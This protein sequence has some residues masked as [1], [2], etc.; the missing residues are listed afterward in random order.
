MRFFVASLLLAGAVFGRPAEAFAADAGVDFFEK[1]IR[2]VLVQ[3]CYEC[4]SAAAK[5]LRG[6]LLL[7]SRDG[8][9]KGGDSG[10]VIEPTSPE[11]S[12]LLKAIRY[13]DDAVQ[14]PPEGKLPDAVIADFE[15]WVKQG[16]PDPRDEPA[17]APSSESWDETLRK[18][19][20][21][22]SYQPLRNPPVPQPTDS[23][24]S[25][26]PVDRFLLAKLEENHL[27]PAPPA[28]P[29]TL[30]RRLSL[31]L[32]GLPPR[33][34]QVADFAAACS[35]ASPDQPLPL[36]AVAALTESLLASPHFGERWARHWLDV[37]R[38]SETH[39]NEWN[40]EV[41]HA[42]RYRDYL[43]RAFNGDVPYDQFVREHIAGDLLRQPRWNE[44]EMF[45][46]SLI[47]TA[48]YRF[49][50]VNHDD[51]ISLP[52]IGYDLADNQIDTLTKAFQATTVACAR[53]HNHKLDAISTEDYYA[54]L[55]VLRSSRQV[56][57]C[58]DAATVNADCIER[59]RQLK[60]ELR[61]E[62]AGVWLQEAQQIARYMQA[63]QARRAQ[64]PDA[65]ALAQGLDARRLEKWLAVLAVEKLPQEDPLEPW[66]ALAT[67]TQAEPT[68]FATQWK[69]L[70]DR[71]AE[72]DDRRQAFN[73]SHFETYADFRRGDVAEWQIGGQGLRRS[74]AQWRVCDTL[75]RRGRGPRDSAGRVLYPSTVRQV[76]RYA[77]FARVAAGQ[78]AHQLSGARRAKQRR[79]TG[80]EQLSAQLQEL[81]CADFRR[82]DVGYLFAA[83][84]PRSLAHVCR[85]NDH[86]RQPQVSRSAIRVGRR[87]EQLSPALGKGG[88]ESSLV[89]WSDARR[90]P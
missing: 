11:E 3:H 65:D 63:A 19:A 54:L 20:T 62:L 28:D 22:W 90:T 86:V 27:T 56:S 39:G 75:R 16:A 69:R 72:E 26:H 37:V 80:L 13:S 29:F 32:T 82:A 60:K 43:I 88:R 44:Q 84:R 45:N 33:A 53:C 83:R 5:K 61:Q 12:L 74:H 36:A 47:G 57:Q 30:A 81:S 38:F 66:R 70:A 87:Q 8:V 85:T 78:E 71:L 50:E 10:A 9:R 49:G 41:H 42:W 73:A 48:F 68:T 23:A 7:D 4:H 59:L 34:D 67:A 2:P 46:E 79:A 55:G 21:W 35:S 31:V 24:W 40:Y 14:M 58:I 89:L 15:A 17:A 25:E 64:Q 52:S 18:R 6:G 51:C 1:K 76:K 77:P